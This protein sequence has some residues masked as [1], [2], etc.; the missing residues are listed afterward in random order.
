M[1][2]IRTA[3]VFNTKLQHKFTLFLKNLWLNFTVTLLGFYFVHPLNIC[4]DKRILDKKK[5][6]II[7]NHLTNYDWIYVLVVLAKLNMYED[8]VIILKDS[9]SKIPVYGYGMKVFGYIFLKRDW[10]KDR[11]ILAK[12][13]VNTKERDKYYMLLFPE[14][15][16]IDYTTHEKS[17]KFCEANPI[18]I[19]DVAF[20][21]KNV[22]MPR[23]TGFNMIFEN[24]K[25]QLDGIVDITLLVHPYQRYP[26]EEFTLY[27][28]FIERSRKLD[29]AILVD[30]IDKNEVD[31]DDWLYKLFNQKEKTIERYK[32]TENKN[33]KRGF[34]RTAD[35]LIGTEMK[36]KLFCVTRIWSRWSEVQVIGSLLTYALLGYFWFR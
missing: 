10:N 33:D 26:S 32:K 14:G 12:G 20:N 29:F 7:S 17:Q 6:I 9:L 27:N 34:K 18:K 23:K 21:P 1:I 11:E 22:L 5:C 35:E 13:L 25:E 3:L 2:I 4:Y 19:D 16:L 31:G 15:T 8:L 36:S 24:L 30:Y 28:V